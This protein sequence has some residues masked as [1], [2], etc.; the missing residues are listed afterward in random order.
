M[1]KKFNEFITESL[2]SS[3]DIDNEMSRIIKDTPEIS[4]LVSDK[5]I[6]IKD[7]KIFFDITDINTVDLL[8]IHLGISPNQ[9]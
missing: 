1:I 8:K 4:N 6:E 9:K 2:S 7:N 3:I 5:K